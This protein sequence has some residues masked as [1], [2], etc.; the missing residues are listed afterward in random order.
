MAYNKT[1]KGLKENYFNKIAM[2]RASFQYFIPKL[3]LN[4]YLTLNVN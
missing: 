4:I 2:V 3:L 1:K